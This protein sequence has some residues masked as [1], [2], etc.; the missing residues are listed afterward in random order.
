MPGQVNDD[1]GC[2]VAPAD[3]LG[4]AYLG[5]TLHLLRPQSSCRVVARYQQVFL[6]DADRLAS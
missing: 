3:D 6:S 4:G 1:F 2:R 5:R